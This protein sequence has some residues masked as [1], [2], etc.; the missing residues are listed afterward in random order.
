VLLPDGPSSAVS[1]LFYSIPKAVAR[2]QRWQK[3]NIMRTIAG[4]LVGEPR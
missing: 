4:P 2:P 3:S 1:R